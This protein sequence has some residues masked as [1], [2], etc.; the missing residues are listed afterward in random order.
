MLL[1]AHPEV[2]TPIGAMENAAIITIKPAG[3]E[4]AANLSDNGNKTNKK[5][6]DEIKIQQAVRKGNSKELKIL[7]EVKAIGIKIYLN[8]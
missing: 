8:E 3:A 6:E 7:E 4:D 5:T 2:K 1:D